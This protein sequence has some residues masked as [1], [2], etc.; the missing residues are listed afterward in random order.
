MIRKL[1]N[2]PWLRVYNMQLSYS[3]SSVL[4][5]HKNAMNCLPNDFEDLAD[6][7][8]M[9]YIELSKNIHSELEGKVLMKPQI[10]LI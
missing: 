5:S 2:S 1:W 10:E 4:H 3:F 6:D 9:K 8:P 7:H